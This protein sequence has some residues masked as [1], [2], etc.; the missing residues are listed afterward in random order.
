MAI[1]KSDQFND[2]D[3]TIY[4]IYK[5][6]PIWHGITNRNTNLS[7]AVIVRRLLKWHQF[8]TTN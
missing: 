6:V 7:E 2:N 8:N 5:V 1:D 4:L 3:Y